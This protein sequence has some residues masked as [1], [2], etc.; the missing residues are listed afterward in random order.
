MFNNH[1]YISN[2]SLMFVIIFLLTLLGTVDAGMRA[3]TEEMI[4]LQ[5]GG[6][7]TRGITASQNP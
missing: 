6:E 5:Y 3:L 1:Y 7:V 2:I 4:A